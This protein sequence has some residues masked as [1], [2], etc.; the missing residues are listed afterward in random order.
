MNGLKLETTRT[1]TAKMNTLPIPC[2]KHLAIPTNLVCGVCG[3]S[4]LFDT[5]ANRRTGFQIVHPRQAGQTEAYQ[6][7][8][9]CSAALNEQNG[10]KK[11]RTIVPHRV[12]R[13]CKLRTAS[14]KEKMLIN[15]TVTTMAD[16][17]TSV[18]K[19]SSAFTISLTLLGSIPRAAF[20]N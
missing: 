7:P 17:K 4:F 19:V 1:K 13:E 18:Q 3:L 9:R 11:N 10:P 8:R 5:N 6:R 14:N 20:K 15:P 12:Q 2:Q 16:P